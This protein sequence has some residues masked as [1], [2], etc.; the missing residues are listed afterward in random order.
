MSAVNILT[1]KS[2]SGNNIV[3]TPININTMLHQKSYDVLS[4]VNDNII[5][6]IKN[7]ITKH[8]VKDD[9]L[10]FDFAKT[11]AN[12]S[13]VFEKLFSE[14]I[15]EYKIILANIEN[16]N[17]HKNL[18]TVLESMDLKYIDYFMDKNHNIV[19][20]SNTNEIRIAELLLECKENIC[21]Q[22]KDLCFMKSKNIHY[23]SNSNLYI[24]DYFTVKNLFS[25]TNLFSYTI[26]KMCEKIVE[27]KDID[28]LICTSNNGAILCNII[29][30]MLNI[31]PLFA[32]N[33]GPNISIK[34]IED[35]EKIERDKKYIYIFDFICIGTEFKIIQTIVRMKKAFISA[36]VGV[37]V[38]LRPDR[39]QNLKDFYGIINVDCSEYK[40]SFYKENLK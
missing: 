33:I 38:Y 36:S 26:N 24:K 13:E 17:I 7:E 21:K 34:D 27:Y 40:V 10:I 22:I 2:N 19:I 35:L 1:I 20:N 32:L 25:D 31:K 15:L 5:K 29:G 16:I 37:G 39:N 11:N 8:V 3:Y 18:I 12:S 6:K 30:D 4:F 14:D 28:G 9:L 23:L